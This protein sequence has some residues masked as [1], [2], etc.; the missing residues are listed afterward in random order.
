MSKRIRL[1][2]YVTVKSM[3]AAFIAKVKKKGNYGMMGTDSFRIIVSL[4]ML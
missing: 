2:V 4:A 1:L 3:K